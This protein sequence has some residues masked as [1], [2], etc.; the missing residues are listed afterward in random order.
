MTEL[1]EHPDVTP[2]AYGFTQTFPVLATDWTSFP[3]H[4][5]LYASAGAF[6]LEVAH[7]RWVL[8]P[9]RAAWIAAEVPIQVSVSAPTTA[10]SVL[11]ARDALPPPPLPCQVFTVSS[12]AR[13]MF[14]YAMRWGRERDPDDL[15]ADRFLLALAAVCRELAESPDHFWLPRGQ[16]PE[17][18]AAMAYTAAHLSEPLQ[19][20]A[21][22]RSA[23]VSARTLARRFTKEAGMPWRAFLQRARM[24]AAMERLAASESNVT[25]TAL[26][27]GFE[28]LSAFSTAFLRFVGERPA[29]YR[30]RFQPQ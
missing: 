13:E 16:S 27:V 15:D 8:P 20:D 29:D 2:L 7:A 28:S 12:L 11:F 14:V 4:Y 23:G 9:Q 1:T 18:I 30:R 3:R 22:A 10:C 17:L 21:V 26:M 19:L 24:I 6:V 5:L 25:E